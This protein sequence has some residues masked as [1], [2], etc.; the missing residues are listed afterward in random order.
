MT[1]KDRLAERI[2]KHDAYC[3]FNKPQGCNCEDIGLLRDVVST[4]TEHQVTDQQGHRATCLCGETFTDG[5]AFKA[6]WLETHDKAA[7]KATKFIGENWRAKAEVV[8][9]SA[10]RMLEHVKP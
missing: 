6:H 2:R 1:L 3:E 10:E 7:R 9:A 8:L 4:L 5:E